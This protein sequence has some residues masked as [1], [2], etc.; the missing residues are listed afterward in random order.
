MKFFFASFIMF[1]GFLAQAQD[2]NP[3]SFEFEIKTEGT[4]R[5]LVAKA[6]VADGWNIYS[7]KNP[8]NGPIPTTIDLENAT[9]VG[10]IIEHGDIITKYDDM[11]MLEVS[12]Y[13]K[14]VEF[15]QAFT[16]VRGSSLKGYV[17]YMCCDD[18]RCLPPVDVT[19]DLSVE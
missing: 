6:T 14:K 2:N 3:V 4:E 16:D 12:K 8:E 1:I 5:L 18:K 17:T 15:A 7:Y 19:F 9:A 10:D 13:K 11:F